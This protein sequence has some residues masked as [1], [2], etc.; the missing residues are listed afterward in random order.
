MLEPTDIRSINMLAIA[1][2]RL[3]QYK[4]C[5]FYA[6]RVLELDANNVSAL[7][8]FATLLR[9]G[10]PE[11]AIKFAERLIID[12]RRPEFYNTQGVL[13]HSVGRSD[14]ALIVYKIYLHRAY[15]LSI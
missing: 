15:K 8:S 4:K 5:S 7:E 13:L 12:P 2:L 6:S 9:N 14:E 10:K 11:A 3:G 1:H